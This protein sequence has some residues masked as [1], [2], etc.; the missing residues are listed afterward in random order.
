[1]V[2]PDSESTSEPPDLHLRSIR[3]IDFNSND[4]QSLVDNPRNHQKVDSCVINVFCALMQ[5]NCEPAAD[6]Y[7]FSSWLG[8]LVQ[9][10]VRNTS[11]IGSFEDNLH[12][13]CFS[14][15]CPASR[16][17]DLTSRR[18]WCIPLCGG[19][20]YHWVLAIIDCEQRNIAIY[21]SLPKLN[22][23][24][25]AR[26][27]CEDIVVHIHD[28]LSAIAL[29]S[30]A[31]PNTVAAPDT[32]A[33]SDTAASDTVAALDVTSW[34]LVLYT[35]P[36]MQGQ[37]DSWSCGLFIMMAMEAVSKNDLSFTTCVHGRITTI[38]QIAMHAAMQI[39]IIKFAVS[40]IDT[41]KNDAGS[42]RIDD[43]E[44]FTITRDPNPIS[45]LPAEPAE[46][47]S[48][49]PD[50]SRSSGTSS[51]AN[52]NSVI[53]SKRKCADSTSVPSSTAKKR[54]A[55]R[56]DATAR[57]DALSSDEWIVSDSVKTVMY[58]LA[59]WNQHKKVCH[60]INSTR[61]IRQ[62]VKSEKRL[63]AADDQ[64]IYAFFARP[65]QAVP[66]GSAKPL[67][68]PSDEF[69]RYKTTKD[70]IKNKVLDTYLASQHHLHLAAE[71]AAYPNLKLLT[72][73]LFPYKS[74][75]SVVKRDADL[76]KLEVPDHGN[77]HV[78]S[79]KWSE[80]E[81]ITMDI[82]LRAFA[83]WEVH[84]EGRCI[85]SSVCARLAP[86]QTEVCKACAKVAKDESF[87]AA[88]RR[89]VAE[90]QLSIEEQL[91]KKLQC[92]K[93]APTTFI[94]GD[95]RMLQAK[96][97]D[98]L[99]SE[100]HIHLERDDN[101]KCF[102]ALAKHATQGK[103]DDHG[104]FADIC[105]VLADRLRRLE[106][107]DAKL[108]H[109]KRYPKNLIGF[110]ILMRSY[111]GNSNKQYQIFS[112]HLPAPSKSLLSAIVS[113]TPDVLQNPALVFEN[114]VRIRS[115]VDKVGYM[116]PIA[117]AGDCTK[118]RAAL[119][120]SDSFGGHIMGST[121]SPEE[122]MIRNHEDIDKV[123]THIES[124]DA[125]AKQVR[126]ILAKIPLPGYPPIVVALIPTTG[127]DDALGIYEQY[128]ILLKM[129][130]QLK[131]N[132]IVTAAD[133]AATEFAAQ[134][135]ADAED[136]G[137]EPLVYEHPTLGYKITVPMRDTGPLV[138]DTDH[139]HGC[140]TVRNQPQH[141]THTASMGTGFLVNRSLLALYET[142]VS[143]LVLSDVKNVDKQDDGA[144][145]R[146]FH[147]DVLKATTDT[148]EGDS[149]HVC[150]GMEGLFAYLFVLGGALECWTSRKM[151][152]AD[153]ILGIAR[154][155]YF[156]HFWRAHIVRLAAKY[157]DLIST[158]RSFISAPSFKILN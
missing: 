84:Y 48:L 39:P 4:L 104:I 63:G 102:L 1:M 75:P 108:K 28:I 129:C 96:F 91:K 24:R 106:T 30:D 61:T 135:M 114:V 26:P 92:E 150:P 32:V 147:F 142:R 98:P 14:P 55:P 151:K 33:M 117:L 74:W 70:N 94:A 72:H 15:G 20:P 66:D 86:M 35:S 103:L 152:P 23:S 2:N 109:G 27:I 121:L 88:V 11:F 57:R 56:M 126:A 82:H 148:D 77:I 68:K 141:G 107:G 53:V 76:L 10:H 81:I 73:Q 16:I 19:Q 45:A 59:N 153:R 9:G 131:L 156:L 139:D 22:S 95:A 112:K 132:V 17:S 64:S 36:E 67:V 143:G 113:K 83:R 111:G 3:G 37:C 58:E 47:T 116:G 38:R 42:D 54:R 31:A 144:A 97:T 8:P 51:Q 125:K 29:G 52:W 79:T 6:F 25:W 124:K 120:Y 85:R 122:C 78:S 137:H 123:I 158:S 21:D 50:T 134:L 146:I 41:Q 145:R 80:Q 18:Y 155:R 127:K 149:I 130:A 110:M 43:Q 40:Q 69:V 128:K 105:K 49:T 99:L 5:Q 90:S 101:T 62:V 133:G 118:I 13:T 87:K 100:L 136:T 60:I 12:R 34:P 44:V 115:F 119:T 138:Q 65:G 157:P 71:T 93:Y 140:K 46:D 7:V 89:K 154:A